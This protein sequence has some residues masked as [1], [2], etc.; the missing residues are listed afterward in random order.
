MFAFHVLSGASASHNGAGTTTLQMLLVLGSFLVPLSRAF[1]FAIFLG[2]CGMLCNQVPGRS[3]PL[4]RFVRLPFRGSIPALLLPLGRAVKPSE[5]ILPYTSKR[6][7]P[8]PGPGSGLSRLLWFLGLGVLCGTHSTAWAMPRP[9]VRFLA[10]LECA[11]ECAL[12]ASP[13][14]LPPSSPHNAWA[15]ACKPDAGSPPPQP[16]TVL[17]PALGSCTCEILA[18]GFPTTSLAL[19]GEVCAS[20]SALAEAQ[21]QWGPDSAVYRSFISCCCALLD[22]DFRQD[23]VC[24]GHEPVFRACLCR[25]W[26]VLG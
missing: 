21:R 1:L 17:R 11:L 5:A 14:L 6:G 13:D 19:P 26:L 18:A 2:L 7:R 23:Y 10:E 25:S 24:P 3:S 9:E 20:A 12:A 4:G 22:I 15:S 16:D 8:A